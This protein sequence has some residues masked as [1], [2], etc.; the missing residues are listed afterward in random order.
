MVISPDST[1]YGGGLFFAGAH[2]ARV[3][4]AWREWVTSLPV[5]MSS[6][7]AF[8]RRQALPEIPAPLRGTFV[9]HVRFSS[10]CSAADAEV[11]LAPI[12]ALAPT[13]LD[14]IAEIP[15]RDAGHVHMDPPEPLPWVEH[16]TALSSFPAEAADA[17]LAAVGPDSGST[18]V[19]A[20]VRALGGALV[21]QPPVPNA[22]SGRSARW[23]FL[24]AG[25]GSPDSAPCMAPNATTSSRTSNTGTTRKPVPR[26]PQHPTS[27]VR[28]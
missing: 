12:R 7:I 22:M 18:L 8:L 26:E 13:V 25:A 17:L 14:T 15:Y 21:E 10:L 27:S 11:A 4:H 3:L 28:I 2:A 6:S 9:V 1:F 19:L 23:A 5:E 16:T 20:E 24:A